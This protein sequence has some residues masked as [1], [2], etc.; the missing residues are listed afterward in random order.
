MTADYLRYT[1][2]HSPRVSTFSHI[3]TS[4]MAETSKPPSEFV[5]PRQI[6]STET[7]SRYEEQKL[8][9]TNHMRQTNRTM[10][11]F[12]PAQNPILY[13]GRHLLS[14][15]SVLS[16]SGADEYGMDP[17]GHFESSSPL[18]DDRFHQRRLRLSRGELDLRQPIRNAMQV[19]GDPA[20][21]AISDD[22]STDS[23]SGSSVKSIVLP[24]G[25]RVDC[26]VRSTNFT[27]STLSMPIRAKRKH[28]LNHSH[29][30]GS[31]SPSSTRPS[32]IF[33]KSISCSTRPSFMSSTAPTIAEA[34]PNTVL[35]FESH[36]TSVVA[37]E[38]L[39]SEDD[40]MI[41]F[42]GMQRPWQSKGRREW[43]W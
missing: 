9:E 38:E 12:D 31:Q 15:L 8:L 36:D 41:G 22:S 19:G 7:K 29:N 13:Q 14:Q 34:S 28:L 23:G 10:N 43:W 16:R 11:T 2:H 39:H 20:V 37:K 17:H 5:S 33:T 21:N 42:V 40:D 25:H 24:L 35:S 4:I 3:Y 32:S 26:P 6:P 18:V 1:R 30:P 27:R